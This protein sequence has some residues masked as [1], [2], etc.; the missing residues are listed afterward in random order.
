[1]LD[2]AYWDG[3]VWRIGLKRFAARL[4]RPWTLTV[5][6][7]RADAPIYLDDM[8]RA[9]LPAGAQVAT[10]EVLRIVPEYRMEV[11]A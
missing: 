10:L 5:M 9:K 2:D 6:P 4:G 8:A 1:M 7:L 11:K 3:R